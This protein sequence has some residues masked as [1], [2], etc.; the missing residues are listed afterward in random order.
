MVFLLPHNILI[1]KR[2]V[3]IML[4]DMRFFLRQTRMVCSLLPVPKELG[5]Y[6]LTPPVVARPDPC[7]LNPV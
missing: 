6:V 3:I 2:L 5:F 7:M 4:L 1:P